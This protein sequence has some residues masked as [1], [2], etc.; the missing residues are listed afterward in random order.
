MTSPAASAVQGTFQ[1]L[2]WAGVGITTYHILH[3]MRVI[4]E[5]YT[6]QRRINLF[7]RGPLYAFSRATA[8][9]SLFTVA[10]VVV[11]SIAHERRR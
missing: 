1:V 6:R 4:N 9:N 7:S 8:A 5:A 10:V 2:T 11:A 3:Q